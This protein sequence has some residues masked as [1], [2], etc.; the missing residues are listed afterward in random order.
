MG[1]VLADAPTGF[2]DVLDG[3]FRGGAARDVLQAVVECVRQLHQTFE[4]VVSRLD[5]VPGDELGE[6]G[7]R[8]HQRARVCEVPIGFSTGADLLP[9]IDVQARGER[10]GGCNL[11]RGAGCDLQD[12]VH[13]VEVEE[14]SR[15]AEA[16][17]LAAQVGWRGCLNLKVEESLPAVLARL[18]TQE[19]H[20]LLDWGRV[21]VVREVF[22]FVADGSGHGVCTGESS[23]A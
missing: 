12:L 1:V 18:Q 19:H 20:A 21:G 8:A 9:S 17:R 2:E 10:W 5:A 23:M 6:C 13:L 16:V 22:D 11:D 14:V 15:V 3:G 7:R 4:R